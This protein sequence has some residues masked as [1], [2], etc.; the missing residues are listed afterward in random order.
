MK[1]LP[2]PWYGSKYSVLSWLL[3]K[4]PQTKCY[5]EP[6]GGAATV[7]LNKEPSEVETYNDLDGEVTNFFKVLR[8]NKEELIRNI[9]YTPYSREEYEKAI[10]KT[11]NPDENLS[12][13]EKARLFYVK[14]GQVYSGLAQKATPGRWS[15][16]ISLSRRGMSKELSQFYNR[17][18][19]LDK[20]SERL[21]RVQI[22]NNNAIDVIK[23]YDNEDCLTYCDPPYIHD[24]RSDNHVYGNEMS[25]EE[26]KKLAETLNNCDGLV[27]ISSYECDLMEDLYS[28]W[29]L[30]KYKEKK[31]LKNKKNQECLWTNYSI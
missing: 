12:D 18:E 14:A 24:T 7:L 1:L 27:A 29:N 21:R 25:N 8:D 22:E 16:T 15:K 10:E 26:H 23:K 17:I 6:Y 9:A 4:L 5:S 20:I 30:H 31:G 2:F 11:N 19:K 28:D 13:I 3:E